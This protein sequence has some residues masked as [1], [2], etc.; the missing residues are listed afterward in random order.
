MFEQSDPNLGIVGV[1]APIFG[2][3]PGREVRLTHESDPVV[4]FDRDG[5]VYTSAL[6]FDPTPGVVGSPSAIVVSRWDRDGRTS[7]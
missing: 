5:N 2:Q 7:D 6:A 3:A 1:T 4:A